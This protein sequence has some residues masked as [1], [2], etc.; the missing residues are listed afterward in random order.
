MEG[1]L[2]FLQNDQTLLLRI[3]DGWQYLSLGEKLR[4]EDDSSSSGGN[5]NIVSSGTIG[6]DNIRGDFFEN[7]SKNEQILDLA[8]AE[9]AGEGFGLNEIAT[10]D[11]LRVSFWQFFRFPFIDFYPFFLS[12]K[13]TAHRSSETLAFDSTESTNVRRYA[14]RTRSGL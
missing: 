11:V 10:N 5:E 1:S 7:K 2:V 8:E 9:K 13:F 14:R 6:E 3:R 4:F 12:E